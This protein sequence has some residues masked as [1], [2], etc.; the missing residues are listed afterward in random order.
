MKDY[1]KPVI[2]G[3][4]ILVLG[5]IVIERSC[6]TSDAKLNQLKRE[7]KAYKEK[8]AENKRALLEKIGKRGEDNLKKDN[9]IE[10]LRAE[11]SSIDEDRQALRRKDEEKAQA[12]YELKEER[13]ALEDPHLIIAN[14][15]LLLKQWEDRWS[16][17]RED[18][19]KVIEQRNAW[20]AV[21]FRQYGKYLNERH[22]RKLLEKQLA[23]QEVLTE[24]GEEIVK[25]Q[26]KKITGLSLKFT[27]GNVF[28]T[29]LGFGLGYITGATR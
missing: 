17:E 3:I 10:E 9:E 1:I 16:L 24:V 26:D 22:S 11:I 7:F 4:T 5:L 28:Y 14:Q 19:N 8:I 12:I 13:E 18:K 23:G 29:A 20:A 25:G 6:P 15:N 27:L 2:I 21:A